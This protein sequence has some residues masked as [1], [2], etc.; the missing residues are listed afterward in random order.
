MAIRKPP[1]PAIRPLWIPDGLD[2]DRLP[3]ALR[4]AVSGILNPAY[5][6]LVLEAPTAL[7]RTAGLTYVHAAWLELI[8]QIELCKSMARLLPSGES[9]EAL[10]EPIAR[11]LRLVGAKEKFGKFLLQIKTFYEKY[12]GELDPLHRLQDY[13]D[14]EGENGNS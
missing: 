2:F 5:R 6:E 3:E 13:V 9:S 4:L 7:L 10:Q 1:P 14:P 11:H 8:D 12:P